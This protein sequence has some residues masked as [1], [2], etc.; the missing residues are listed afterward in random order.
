MASR[1]YLFEMV[2]FGLLF[3]FIFDMVVKPFS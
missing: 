3:L 2:D 1:F